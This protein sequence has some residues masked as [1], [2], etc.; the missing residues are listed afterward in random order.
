MHYVTELIEQI[1]KSETAETVLDWIPPVYGNAYT[2]I[3][4]LEVIGQ[5]VDDMNSWIES[6]EKQLT[7]TT[8]TWSLPYWEERYG[9]TVNPDIPIDVRRQAIVVK[10]N[11]RMP[12]NPARMEQLV[13]AETGC[14]TLVT[15][16]VATNTFRVFCQGYITDIEGRVRQIIDKNKPSHLIYELQSAF[17]EKAETITYMGTERSTYEKYRVEVV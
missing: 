2:F 15:D 5:E 9:I 11:S 17:L 4:M 10:R 7:P 8:A 14:P 12:M 6:Y 1:I 3:W 16:G 13:T